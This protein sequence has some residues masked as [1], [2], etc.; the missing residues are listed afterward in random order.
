MLSP[1][2]NKTLSSIYQQVRG[3][4]RWS[5]KRDARVVAPLVEPNKSYEVV[6]RLRGG[7]GTPKKRVVVVEEARGQQERWEMAQLIM[8]MRQVVGEGSARYTWVDGGEEDELWQQMRKEWA[9][10]GMEVLKK[11]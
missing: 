5:T 7:K 4:Q 3:Y 10:S 1:Q 6:Q 11:S 9:R 8:G 2:P